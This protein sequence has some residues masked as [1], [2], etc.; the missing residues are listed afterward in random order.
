MY[1]YILRKSG[2]YTVEHR[3]RE[4]ESLKNRQVK[5]GQGRSS[6]RVLSRKRTSLWLL[7][8]ES[9]RAR[10]A[11]ALAAYGGGGAAGNENEEEVEAAKE[12]GA[13]AGAG[14]TVPATRIFAA[15]ELHGDCSQ[16]ARSRAHD[17]AA[18]VG[19]GGGVYVEKNSFDPQA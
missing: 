10:A 3:L 17:A 6:S 5:V 13:G 7:E 14:A 4:W 15:E 11:E 1:R 18:A 16:G 8:E 2:V 9:G 12:G 19:G